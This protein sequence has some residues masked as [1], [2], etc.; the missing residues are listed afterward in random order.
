M[1]LPIACTLFLPFL[2][3]M[4][5]HL[6]LPGAAV[7]KGE[8]AAAFFRS[9]W[10]SGQALISGG[11]LSGGVA[12]F[13]R[14]FFSQFAALVLL[15]IVLYKVS[16]HLEFRRRRE[17]LP[18]FD[19]PETEDLE[20]WAEFDEPEASSEAEDPETLPELDEPEAF[21]E[22]EDTPEPGM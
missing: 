11:V 14:A 22:A 8:G 17:T 16:S 1:G 9:L 7:T 15:L 10:D 19:E 20:T 21:S 6:L 4:L 13:C 12:E 5:G 2:F 3:G 18:E